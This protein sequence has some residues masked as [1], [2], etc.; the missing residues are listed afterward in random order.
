MRKWIKWVIAA[1]VSLSIYAGQRDEIINLA[2]TADKLVRQKDGRTVGIDAD[3]KAKVTLARAA[4]PA[5]FANGLSDALMLPKPRLEK[6]LK[7][8]H[9]IS[10]ITFAQI[11]A[12]KK[13]L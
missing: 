7:K 6:L 5:E 8:H 2:G 1:G 12:L 9:S 11:I 4:T 3:G 10:G 13:G